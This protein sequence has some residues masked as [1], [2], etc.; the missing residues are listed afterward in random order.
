MPADA[1]GV[2]WRAIGLADVAAIADL[3]G[4]LAAVDHPHYRETH[5][6]IERGLLL[7]TVDLARDTMLAVDDGGRALAWGH[8][9]RPSGAATTE[10]AILAG[11]VRPSARRRGLGSA[12]A[13]WQADRGRQLL[14]ESGSALPG[15]LVAGAHADHGPAVDLWARHGLAVTR[16]YLGLDRELA[17][18][19]PELGVAA[20]LRLEP[21]RAELSEAVR[22]AKNDAFRDHWGMQPT[23]EERWAGVVEAE[24]F[25][26]QFS[27]VVLDERDEVAGFVLTESDPEDWPGIGRS[28]VYL[29]LLGV[30]RAARGQRLAPALLAASLRA[31]AAAGLEIASLD[32]DLES[33]T[34]AV[35]LYTRMGFVEAHRSVQLVR[36]L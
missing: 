32:V 18:P 29:S 12:L 23:D 7:S 1:P 19:I 26:P 35:G 22:A 5:E 2:H 25:T 8:V 30:R 3:E 11:G 27:F 13:A 31:A 9:I 15:W 16:Y 4:E 28:S 33:P 21:Y 17:D 34:G 36:E 6:A 20:P 10:R 14:A 24:V